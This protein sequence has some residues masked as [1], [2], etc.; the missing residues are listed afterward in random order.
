MKKIII[1]NL[2]FSIHNNPEE[3]LSILLPIHTLK[4]LKIITG[5]IIISVKI[6]LIL[7]VPC[8]IPVSFQIQVKTIL[9][10]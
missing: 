3:F 9:I 2:G 5:I 10:I 4:V 8:K 6:Y 1:V 7:P